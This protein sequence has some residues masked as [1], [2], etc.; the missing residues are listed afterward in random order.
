MR[1]AHT[2]LL[3]A[4]I[5]GGLLVGALP[6]A[7]ADDVVVNGSGWG[8]GVGLSQYGAKGQA[9]EGRT[10]EQILTHYFQGTSVVDI[11]TAISGS[12]VLSEPEPVWVNLLQGRASLN[13]KAFGSGLVICQNEPSDLLL[14]QGDHS[15]YVILLESQLVSTGH[16]AGTPDT[17]FDNVTK[18]A[19]KA[20]QTDNGLAADGIV[21]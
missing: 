8:H 21:G 15:S 5:L 4:M 17:I 6:A 2:T 13:V 16:F 10:A 20:F 9:D 19:V 1:T 12:W 18:S 7:A 3:T 11:G 14:K